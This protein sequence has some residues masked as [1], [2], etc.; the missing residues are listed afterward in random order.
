MILLIVPTVLASAFQLRT[1]DPGPYEAIATVALVLCTGLQFL[2]F[3][4]ILRIVSY[5]LQTKQDILDS[6]KVDVE[7][8]EYEKAQVDLDTELA[9]VTLLSTL[10]PTW[11]AVLLTSA[12][13]VTASSYLIMMV[14]ASCFVEFSL[15][16]DRV[17]DMCFWS[18]CEMV[19]LKP[20]GAVALA[21]LALGM[22]G[23][24][25]FSMWAAA[26]TSSA[27]KSVPKME[28]ATGD[29][30]EPAK[31]ARPSQTNDPPKHQQDL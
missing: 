30:T 13:F 6:Y 29:A 23:S 5:V 10:P 4:G 14:P 2:A 7:V 11:R 16:R 18:G 20:L 25:A 27:K 22:V 17:Q 24:K 15:S 26:Q 28:G 3:I 12:W 8:Q 31:E 9:R 19:F 21:M 1:N